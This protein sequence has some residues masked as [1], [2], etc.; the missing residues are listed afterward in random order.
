MSTLLAYFQLANLSFVPFQIKMIG[1]I[2]LC[3]AIALFTWA[4]YKWATINNDYFERRGVKYRKP[5]FLFGSTAEMFFQKSNAIEFN[6]K[7][8][9]AFPNES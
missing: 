6:T 3:A 5:T 8:Y 7:L 2:L 4:F 1:E 9:N